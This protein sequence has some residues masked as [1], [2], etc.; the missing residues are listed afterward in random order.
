MTANNREI[1]FRDINL[2]QITPDPDQPRKHF[3]PVKLDELAQS[4][5][6]NGLLSP[7]MVRPV[8]DAFVIVHGE[9]RYRAVQSLGWAAILCE[10]RELTETDAARLALVE[11]IQ[12]DDLTPMEEARAYQGYMAQ[13]KT[14]Q[15]QLGEAVGKTQSYIAQKLRLLNLEAPLVALM[16]HC[17]MSEGHMRQLM[18]LRKFFDGSEYTMWLK[19]RDGEPVPPARTWPFK[20]QPDVFLLSH[21][22]ALKPLE[23]WF[24]LYCF[25]EELEPKWTAVTEVLCILD[26]WIHELDGIYP[27]WVMNAV[28]IG[29]TA[30][31]YGAT[32]SSLAA[33]VDTYIEIVTGAIW[34][35]ADERMDDFTEKAI[36]R[37][38]D[39]DGKAE[40]AMD[41]TMIGLRADLHHAGLWINDNPKEKRFVGAPS[42][43][44][45]FKDL[46]KDAGDSVRCYS[47]RDWWDAVTKMAEEAA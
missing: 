23:Y 34:A 14:T 30:Y 39:N 24:P 37:A 9:R 31:Q 6:E 22:L 21:D 17:Q 45:R 28:H 47:S 29:L 7:I 46:H 11:N 12:R 38:K 18:R 44:E 41:R 40:N 1:M 10:I 26:D 15:Q 42:L 35:A 16:E 5:K 13:T 32:V 36:Q 8:G 43:L 2:A 4:I 27:T 33:H 3:N 20:D 19:T 25:D